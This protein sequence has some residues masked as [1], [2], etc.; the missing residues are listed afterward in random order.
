LGYLQVTGEI[1][2]TIR[3]TTMRAPLCCG[4]FDRLKQQRAEPGRRFFSS[5]DMN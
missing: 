2:L 1:I 5:I 4:R 3:I